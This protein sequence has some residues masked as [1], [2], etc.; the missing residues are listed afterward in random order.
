[1]LDLK[2]VL[3]AIPKKADDEESR[4]LTTAWGDVILTSAAE[5]LAAGDAKASVK[6]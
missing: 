1:M 5:A 2:R 4:R 3:A 6:T